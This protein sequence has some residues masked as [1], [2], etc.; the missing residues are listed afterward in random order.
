V[1]LCS[2]H[3]VYAACN[4]IDVL[5]LHCSTSGVLVSWFYFCFIICN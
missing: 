2:K 1:K 3:Y 4:S 5:L